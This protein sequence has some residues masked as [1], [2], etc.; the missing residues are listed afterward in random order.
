MDGSGWRK[1]LDRLLG[2]AIAAVWL[3]NGLYCKVL[4]MVPRHQQIVGE[5]LS[6]DHAFWLTKV[7]GFG[8]V[9][10]GLWVL[11][12]RYGKLATVVQIVLVMVMN[13]LEFFL[14]PDVL[15]WGGLNLFFAILFSVVLFWRGFVFS[16]ERGALL[17]FIKNHPFAVE[18]F[19][20]SSTVLT[21]AFPK[22]QLRELVPECLELDTFDDKWA[23]VAVAMV[24]TENMRPKGFPAFLGRDFFLMGYRVFVR[25]QTS[26]GRRLRGLYILKSD[27]NSRFMKVMGNI[28][29]DY[30]YEAM[31]MNVFDRGFSAGV[32]VP[33]TGFEVTFDKKKEESE[34]VGLPEGTPF[35]DWKQ[36]RRFAGPMPFTFSYKEDTQEVL[37]IEGVRSHWQPRPITVKDYKVPFLKSITQESP[38]LASAFIV[39]NIPYFWRKGQTDSW[40]KT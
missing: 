11:S 4:D 25:Y 21:F 3:I 12:R 20:K 9:M 23:F 38:V 35:A 15:L 17:P 30:R 18:A 22:D 37:M 1:C 2:F 24:Q 6:E 33:T 40:R 7:I 36:A 31:K 32:A 19:F 16:Q 8:E 5:I 29:T 14:V 10:I 13:V 28:M 34:E 26:S 27:T 39:E